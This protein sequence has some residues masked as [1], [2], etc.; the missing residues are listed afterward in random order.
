[1]PLRR[2]RP[3]GHARDGAAPSDVPSA[4]RAPT[5]GR[6]HIGPETPRFS[7]ALS[8]F[9]RA[10]R[11]LSRWDRPASETRRRAAARGRPRRNSSATPVTRTSA[12][13]QFN[14][15]DAS[16]ASLSFWPSYQRCQGSWRGGRDA[17]LRR[18]VLGVGRLAA[19]CGWGSARFGTGRG[20]GVCCIGVIR[21]E[22]R[23]ARCVSRGGGWSDGLRRRKSHQ[24]GLPAGM[25]RRQ[26][27]WITNHMR[28]L[29]DCAHFQPERQ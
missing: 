10:G 17:V 14:R 7:S 29:N 5:A 4:H 24:Q 26:V 23:T 16:S 1:V 22:Q 25:A 20:F 19:S 6:E 9:V 18:A 28:R 15:K 3:A 12:A 27:S 2:T 8:Y 13:R 21:D 11:I